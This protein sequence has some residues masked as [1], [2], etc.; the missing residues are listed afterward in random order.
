MA[1]IDQ[2]KILL[3]EL[4]GKKPTQLISKD[5]TSYDPFADGNGI[6]YSQFNELLL[7]FN[8]NRISHSFFQFLVN[9]SLEFQENSKI[10]SILHFKE[11]V[12]NFQRVAIFYFGSI[13]NAYKILSRDII[14][15]KYYLS[16]TQERPISTY[17][18]RH[19]AILPIDKIPAEKTYYLGY[20]TQ[21]QLEEKLKAQPDDKEL[22]AEQKEVEEFIEKGRKN[23]EAYLTSDH[24]DIYVATSMREK[25]EYLYINKVTD[26]IFNK[27]ELKDYKLRW[28]DPTQAY[29]DD[30]IDKGLSEA[31][32]LKRAKCT[33]YLAQESDTLGKDSELATTLAQG[34]PV[35]AF[36]PE[37]NRSFIEE[38]IR[39]IKSTED[40]IDERDVLYFILKLVNPKILWD[41][42]TLRVGLDEPNTI[43]L[44]ELKNLVVTNL[45]NH[46]NKRAKILKEQHPLGIQV[47]LA[48]GVANGL[49]VV[50]KIDDIIKLI[51]RI[52]TR[53]LDFNLSSQIKRENKYILLTEEISQCVYRIVTGD[54][55]LTNSFWNFYLETNP[56]D[57][58]PKY[59]NK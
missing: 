17:R 55:L 20:I 56:D 41:N 7:A 4:T 32:M 12:A 57:F 31:L 14:K 44:E 36:V 40:F 3:E 49:L 18:N 16:E 53:T 47:N 59:Q 26:Q 25:H 27:S 37:I 19:K 6:G 11:S 46:Y 54:E 2:I 15:L 35:I 34:K 23:H 1:A 48:T 13:K 28:F 5:I 38:L 45:E 50:R 51:K 43:E 21:K 22:Q 9:G 58:L 42:K 29:C 33:I 8:Y 30:R 52:I 24:L 39:D 10:N